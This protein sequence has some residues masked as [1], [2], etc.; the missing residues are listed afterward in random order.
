MPLQPQLRLDAGAGRE[1]CLQRFGG[2][3]A[4]QH[5]AEAGEQF[6]AEAQ[7]AAPPDDDFAVQAKLG[8]RAADV[9]H[10]IALVVGAGDDQSGVHH[11]VG[12]QFASAEPADV[13]RRRQLERPALQVFAGFDA[14]RRH[15]Q[16]QAG[17]AA[18]QQR[19]G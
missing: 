5:Q 11:R 13:Q 3:Q 9:S 1:V 8:D 12:Q 4:V 14:R 2:R 10:E 15:A 18:D 17:A 16:H 6:G 19:P 7:F